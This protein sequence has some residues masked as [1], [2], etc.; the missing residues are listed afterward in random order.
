MQEHNT[1]IGCIDGSGT[2]ILLFF[3][4]LKMTWFWKTLD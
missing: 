4:M 3:S 2:H 1:Y